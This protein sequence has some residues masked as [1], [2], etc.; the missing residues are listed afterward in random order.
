M[1]PRIVID[2]KICNP[3][4]YDFHFCAHARMIGTSTPTHYHV[5]L[6]EI[7][8]IFKNS[9]NTIKI[10]KN[11]CFLVP[12]WREITLAVLKFKLEIIILDFIYEVI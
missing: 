9:K 6:D 3:H 10:L 11:T 4:N 1:P 5:L 7:I 12:L 8:K 2:N